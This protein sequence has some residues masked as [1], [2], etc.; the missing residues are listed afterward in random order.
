[1]SIPPEVSD[2]AFSCTNLSSAALP[3][4][5]ETGTQSWW[6]I[7]VPWVTVQVAAP[8]SISREELSLSLSL[9]KLE[10]G[11]EGPWEEGVS[12]GLLPGQV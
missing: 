1:M 3:L 2:S 5:G 8:G 10:E 11:P 9:E 4:R 12:E 7:C 6:D